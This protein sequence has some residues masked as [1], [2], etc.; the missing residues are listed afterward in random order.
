M[1][2]LGS[3]EKT[4]LLDTDYHKDLVLLQ[5]KQHMWMMILG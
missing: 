3:E 4:W 2:I 5:T 1:F